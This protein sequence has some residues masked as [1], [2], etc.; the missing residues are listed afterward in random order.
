MKNITKQYQELLEGKISRANFVR[1]VRMQFPDYISPVTSLD[2]AVK[3]LKSKRIITEDI[4]DNYRTFYLVNHGEVVDSIKA[5]DMRSA[6]NQF[7]ND[8]EGMMSG[9][10]VTDVHPDS[11]DEGIDKELEAA[12]EEARK[13]SE[14]GYVQHVNKTSYGYTVSDWYDGDSTV[15]SYENGESLNETAEIVEA[16]AG[17]KITAD[18]IKG[19]MYMLNIDM[20]NAF[21]EIK[22]EITDKEW[23]EHEPQT[24]YHPGVG[25]GLQYVDYRVVDSMVT[26][27]GDD[28]PRPATP[29]E[30]NMIESNA[31]IQEEIQNVLIPV[32]EKHEDMYEGVEEGLDADLTTQVDTLSDIEKEDLIKMLL[33][34]LKKKKP[35]IIQKLKRAVIHSTQSKPGE[36][37]PTRPYGVDAQAWSQVFEKDTINEAAEKSEGSYKK[38]TG[39]DLYAHFGELDRVNP[40]E[41][42]KGLAIEMGMRYLPTPNTIT[43]NFNPE[44]ILKATKKVLK[45]LEKDPAYYTNSISAEFEKK[46]GLHQ[47]PKEVK[48][49]SAGMIKIT[50]FNNAKANTET[51]LNKKEAA[52]GKPEGVKEMKPSKKGNQGMKMM[53]SNG[54]LPKG[55]EMMKEG[56]EK[57][58]KV[59]IDPEVFPM[60]NDPDKQVYSLPHVYTELTPDEVYTVNDFLGK[61]AELVTSKGEKAGYVNPQFLI[62]TTTNNEISMQKMTK[63]QMKEYLVREIKKALNTK[64]MKKEDIK[65]DIAKSQKD[66]DI[67]QQNPAAKTAA[68]KLSDL[69]KQMASGKK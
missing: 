37:D 43:D 47:K 61:D 31:K 67:A 54:K 11:I 65:S 69:Y 5:P 17:V 14:E 7:Y 52:K 19:D 30:I 58:D 27:Y 46:S 33:R 57:G 15:A 38:V 22:V 68:A 53:K 28:E 42:R 45:N 36:I 23:A 35:G 26:P 40:Y 12:K 4:H 64:G 34:Q 6:E 41:L 39:K 9:W 62:P 50:G 49:D 20:D 66:L 63:A 29:E 44:A 25:G 55:V 13:N 2:D 1:N 3:I 59:K 24:L 60:I 32:V 48:T 16:L 8:Y 21:Y 10:V 18:R 56:I 51:S